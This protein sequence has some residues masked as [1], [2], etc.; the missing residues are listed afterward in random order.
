[1]GRRTGAKTVAIIQARMGSTRLPG[2]V[3][4]RIGDDTMLHWVVKRTLRAKRVGEAVVATTTNGIDDAVSLEA[5]KAGAEV[6]RGSETDVLDRYRRA[7][8]AH[9][10]EIVVRVTADCPLIDPAV[11]DEVVR[12]FEEDGV[13]Y[14]S[15]TIE[16]SY[17]LGL[18][19]EVV[20]QDALECAW[21]E[22]VKDY[23]RIHVTPYIY[24]HP[25]RFSLLSVRA[26]GDYSSN[27]WTVDT[28]EDLRFVRAVCAR[29]DRNTFSWQDVLRLLEREPSLV[30]LNQQVRQKRLEEG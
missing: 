28:E 20:H 6:F 10:A 21:A 23:H 8:Q 17:P 2:K 4:K 25:D 5:E 1:M 30:R 3:L 7:A 11:I 9:G 16:R 15:N 26:D 19:V 29:F 13:D 14:A 27:R 22:A 18:D 24:Q 12:R